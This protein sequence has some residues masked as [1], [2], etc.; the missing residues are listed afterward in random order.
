M[1]CNQLEI[2]NDMLEWNQPLEYNLTTRG[3]LQFLISQF[4]RIERLDLKHPFEYNLPG[5]TCGF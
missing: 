5:E 4:V 1:A 3:H 2:Y